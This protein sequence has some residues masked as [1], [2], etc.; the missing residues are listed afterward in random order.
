MLYCV[1]MPHFCTYTEYLFA[2]DQS[3]MRKVQTGERIMRISLSAL[4]DIQFLLTLFLTLTPFRLECG[5][6]RILVQ[7][8][9]KRIN[10]EIMKNINKIYAKACVSYCSATQVCRLPKF[11]TC[12][13]N[14]KGQM[15]LILKQMEQVLIT[16]I[17]KSTMKDGSQRF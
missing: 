16:V 10:N 9:T 13:E 14:G 2:H 5:M 17:C 15:I 12:L 8:L 4:L 1:L 6:D 3:R 7:E 11:V